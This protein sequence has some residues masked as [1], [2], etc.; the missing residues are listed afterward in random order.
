[1][2]G[3]EIP[4]KLRDFIKKSKACK[5]LDID[6]KLIVDPRARVKARKKYEEKKE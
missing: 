5:Q 6:S 1:M 4:Q 2:H 3:I